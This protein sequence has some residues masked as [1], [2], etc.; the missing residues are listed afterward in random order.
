MRF[1]LRKKVKVDVDLQ[2][3]K[4][5]GNGETNQALPNYQLRGKKKNYLNKSKPS[6]YKY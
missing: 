2:P 1:E 6:S 4:I 5:S 3:A